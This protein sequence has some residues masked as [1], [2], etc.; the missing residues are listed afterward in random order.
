[1]KGKTTRKEEKKGDENIMSKRIYGVLDINE[2]IPMINLVM[3]MYLLSHLG[4]LVL[5]SPYPLHA[6]E[7]C[8]TSFVFA[9]Q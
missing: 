1:M 3:C 7:A 6:V 9:S 5:N 8:P 2:I 4:S